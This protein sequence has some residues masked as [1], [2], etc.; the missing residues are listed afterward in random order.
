MAVRYRPRVLLIVHDPWVTHGQTRLHQHMGWNDPYVLAQQYIADIK[1]ASHGLV[2]Y[3]I[4]RALD[5]PW[6]PPKIDGFRYTMT[7]YLSRWS[8]RDMH[9]PD[10]LDYQRRLEHFELVSLLNRDVYDEVW[11]FSFPYAGEYESLM[12]GPSAIWCNAPPILRPDA[13]RNSVIMGFN[14][15]RDVGCMLENFG[16]RVESIMAAQYARRPD[17]ENL[18]DAFTRY[19]QRHPGQAACGNV[20]FAPNSTRDYEWGRGTAVLASCD[21]WRD[22]PATAGAPPRL[23]DAR[24][25]GGGDMRAHH[26]WWLQHLPHTPGRID[27]VWGDWWRTCLLLEADPLLAE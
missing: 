10:A 16:H 3:Q 7:D 14:Y 8:R 5:A 25:W 13:R 15:E 12:F 11:V 4:V 1:T 26:I 23:V 2:A 19:D 9:Q 22:Y 21:R 6:F 24:E 18:W 20:H 17:I 27:G